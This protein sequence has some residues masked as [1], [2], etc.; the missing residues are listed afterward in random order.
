MLGRREDAIR[1]LRSVI[2]RAP[3]SNEAKLAA[4]LLAKLGAK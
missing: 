2:E 4:D 1:E 3:R